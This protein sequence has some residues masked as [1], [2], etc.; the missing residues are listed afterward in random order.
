MAHLSHEELNKLLKKVS[1]SVEIGQI[2]CHYKNPDNKYEVV[3]LGFLE[4]SET[5][6]VAYK[7]LYGE[8]FVWVREFDDWM[9]VVQT[10]LGEVR[11]FQLV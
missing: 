10:D 11:R 1:E 8:G 7:A 2:Y 4:A 6:C 9:S 5:P 3:A